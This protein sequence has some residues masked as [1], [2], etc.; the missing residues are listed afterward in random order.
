M[1]HFDSSQLQ[2]ENARRKLISL[3]WIHLLYKV[4]K[5]MSQSNKGTAVI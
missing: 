4:R 5:M 1:K 2:T 3:R